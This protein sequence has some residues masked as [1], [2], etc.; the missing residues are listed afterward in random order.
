MIIVDDLRA[1]NLDFKGA[2]PHLDA[3]AQ[4]GVRFTAA[5]AQ[6]SLC[7]PSRSSV[8]TGLRPDTTGVS[9]LKTHFRDR[10]PSVI[11]LPEM[12][13]LNGFRTFG[14]GKIFHRGFDDEPSWSYP[15]PKVSR[16]IM[17]NQHRSRR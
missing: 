7:S 12:L 3:L 10:I 5:F 15:L 17:I 9:D 6:Y 1:D 2:T 16:I 4:R 8:L 13:R 14:A 11:T